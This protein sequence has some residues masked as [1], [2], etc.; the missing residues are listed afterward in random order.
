MT[1]LWRFS[2]HLL[3]LNSVHMATAYQVPLHFDQQFIQI[4]RFLGNSLSIRSVVNEVLGQKRPIV[5]SRLEQTLHQGHCMFGMHFVMLF[6]VICKSGSQWVPLSLWLRWFKLRPIESISQQFM[7]YYVSFT[8]SM[9]MEVGNT[10]LWS[11]W[12]KTQPAMCWQQKESGLQL[13][14]ILELLHHE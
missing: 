3:E 8:S 14:L 2:V 7:T 11:C 12:L 1:F 10:R 6:R 13:L 4:C 9:C 5:K